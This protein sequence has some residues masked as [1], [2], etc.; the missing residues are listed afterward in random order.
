M[1]LVA[2][3][4]H[5]LPVALLLLAWEAIS[6]FGIVAPEVLPP[7]SA[8]AR[9]WWD[10]ALSGDLAEQGWRSL[11]RSLAGLGA[12]VTLGVILGLSMASSRMVRLLFN[13]IVQLFYPM[14]KSALIPVVLIW[15]GLGDMS[16]TSLIFLGCLLPVVISAYNGARGVNPLLHWSAASL[17]ASRLGIALGVTLPAA[18][19]EILNGVRTALAFSFILLVSSELVIARDGLGYMISFLGESGSYPALFAVIF[20][21][22]ALG[23]FADRTYAALVSFLLRWREA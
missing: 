15:F 12:A 21:V 11:S 9:S 23:F 18:L 5:Y 19:P 6:T 1:A 13:P 14:P 22:A 7:F 17:G 2:V 8:V 10:M 16:K 4:I 20:T 3:M